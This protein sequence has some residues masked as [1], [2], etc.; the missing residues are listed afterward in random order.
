M[1]QVLLASWSCDWQLLVIPLH[2]CSLMAL[3]F[4]MVY[5]FILQKFMPRPASLRGLLRPLRFGFC[6]FT[7]KP[8]LTQS[9]LQD[10]HFFLGVLHF[11]RY[12][13][14]I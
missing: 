1:Y 11:H 13:F 12:T 4:R 3:P 8:S 7:G 6:S 9:V 2:S 14:G 10:A 5:H